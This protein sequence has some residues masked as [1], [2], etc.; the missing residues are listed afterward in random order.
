[1]VKIPLKQQL[2]VGGLSFRN[3]KPRHKE[4]MGLPKAIQ[5]IKNRAR[6]WTQGTGL[7]GHFSLTQEIY[8]L[9]T[10]RMTLWD[11]LYFLALVAKN[12]HNSHHLTVGRKLWSDWD[13]SQL[14]TRMYEHIHMHIFYIKLWNFLPKKI[15]GSLL[16]ENLQ[17]HSGDIQEQS[18]GHSM[19]WKER[20]SKPSL[21]LG[22]SIADSV[23]LF[24][25]RNICYSSYI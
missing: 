15:V 3:R 12:W 10:Q 9:V 22:C 5:L 19:M 24:L 13:D 2:L 25:Q 11:L 21:H 7:P 14:Y 23:F 6:P 8:F 16:M 4:R 20:K 17:W 18:R 1:M